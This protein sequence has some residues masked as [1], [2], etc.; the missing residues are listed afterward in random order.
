MKIPHHASSNSQMSVLS[1]LERLRPGPKPEAAVKGKVDIYLGRL[2]TPSKLSWGTS[3]ERQSLA[4]SPGGWGR[5]CEES[6]WNPVWVSEKSHFI[7][8]AFLLFQFHT[9]DQADNYSIIK[10]I[11]K[12]AKRFFWKVFAVFICFENETSLYDMTLSVNLWGESNYFLA[13]FALLSFH[14][15]S[16]LVN[17]VGLIMEGLHTN[18]GRHKH[19]TPQVWIPVWLWKLDFKFTHSAVIKVKG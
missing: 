3:P 8:G 10:M 2:M 19:W 17:P 14:G 16:A 13:N 7:T 18:V 4:T 1:S 11:H 15:G 5:G 12:N 9:A 6:T